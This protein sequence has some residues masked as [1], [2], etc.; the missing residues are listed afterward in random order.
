M[1]R[2]Q[3]DDLRSQIY[4][5]ICSMYNV[6]PDAG[7][8]M[9]TWDEIELETDWSGPNAM[10]EVNSARFLDKEYGYLCVEYEE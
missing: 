4:K 9:E 7:I 10:A 1:N 5:Q 6:T 8:D 2:E 3:F